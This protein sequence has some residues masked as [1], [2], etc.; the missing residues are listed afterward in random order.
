MRTFEKT[1][2][3]TGVLAEPSARWTAVSWRRKNIANAPPELTRRYAVPSSPTCPFAPTRPRMIGPA[4]ATDATL[5]KS[6]SAPTAMRD[7]HTMRRIASRSL[8]PNACAIIAV[9]AVVRP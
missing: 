6:E 2:S 8:R 7:C 9:D 3:A 5:K 1:S 4:S